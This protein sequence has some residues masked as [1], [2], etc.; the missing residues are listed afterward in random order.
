MSHKK[1]HDYYN[2]KY[3]PDEESEEEAQRYQNNK[4]YG[5]ETSN[6]KQ[7]HVYELF[8][9]NEFLK[10]ISIIN[11][12]T[13][14]S[15][16]P[17][18]HGALEK[19]ALLWA[20]HPD[21]GLF[22]WNLFNQQAPF[23]K[24]PP[25]FFNEET[26]YEQFVKIDR[27][28]VKFRF[29]G[30]ENGDHFLSETCPELLPVPGS[31]DLMVVKNQHPTKKNELHCFLADLKNEAVVGKDFDFSQ[32]DGYG[33]QESTDK[34]GAS[35]YQ[36]K[37]L[38]KDSFFL[39]TTNAREALVSWVDITS[40]KVRSSVGSARLLDMIGKASYYCSIDFCHT[41][42]RLF[43][44]DNNG[45]VTIGDLRMDETK[46]KRVDVVPLQSMLSNFKVSHWVESTKEASKNVQVLV[47]DN[48]VFTSCQHQIQVFDTRKFSPAMTTPL[49]ANIDLVGMN[50]L[51]EDSTIWFNNSAALVFGQFVAAE[52]KKYSYLKAERIISGHM[53]DMIVYKSS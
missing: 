22:R 47:K 15:Y 46:L 31:E 29:G 16:L 17:P 33:K 14:V 10:E 32:I 34:A 8:G 42:N 53:F 41:T 11:T 52:K 5:I 6:N 1:Q 35:S 3:F 18:I 51:R 2:S 9:E 40:G 7:L 12:P 37:M 30:V 20:H 26:S 23:F 28:W 48:Y 13:G 24:I 39:T 44:G 38:N 4:Y 19:E 49:V 36:F 27:S 25:A 21:A 43:A 50:P 45:N